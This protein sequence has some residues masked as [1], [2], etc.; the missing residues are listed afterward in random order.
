M[1]IAA[2]FGNVSSS[3][4]IIFVNKV[5]MSRTGYG[6]RYGIPL[7]WQHILNELTS[8]FKAI[9]LCCR[10]VGNY[11]AALDCVFVLAATTLCAFH[12]I[13]CTLSIWL[14]QAL[15]GVKAV[16]LPLNGTLLC[17]GMLPATT[18]TSGL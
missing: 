8:I 16:K 11:Q 1:D 3:V 15:G 9:R 6:F 5:L 14:T 2:W 7:G 10:H 12:Y 4:L 17:S 13:V 18:S